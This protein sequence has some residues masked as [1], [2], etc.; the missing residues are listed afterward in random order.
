MKCPYCIPNS[1]STSK[2]HRGAIKRH[3]IMNTAP[4]GSQISLFVK[5]RGPRDP[6]IVTISCDAFVAELKK[7]IMDE[8]HV[9]SAPDDVTLQLEEPAQPPRRLHG[10][11]TLREERVEDRAQITLNVPNTVLTS[12]R[13]LAFN[14][15]PSDSD[16]RRARV[17][18]YSRQMLVPAFGAPTQDTLASLSVLIVGGGGLG[19][20]VAMYLAGAG[21]GRITVVDGDTV[22]VSNLHRQVAH[23]EA[24]CGTRKA[25]SLC[26]AMRALNSRGCFD[27]IGEHLTVSNAAA[28]VAAADIVVDCTD[29]SGSRYLINDACVF[30]GVPLV[31]GAALGTDGQLS[32]Y[33]H[34]GG[35]CYRCIFPVPPPR[36]VR[37]GGSCSNAGVLGPVTGVIGSLQAME[38]LKIASLMA[39]QKAHVHVAAHGGATNQPLRGNQPLHGGVGVLGNAQPFLSPFEGFAGGVLSGR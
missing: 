26:A 6:G 30:A 16:S 23:T 39:A 12:R 38:V 11:R 10:A 15:A 37:E 36:I 29:N 24:R 4:A 17:L 8:F 3:V 1:Y 14:A 32:V 9:Q 22:D 21:V 5:R 34:G 13:H 35:P 19:C 33:N 28:I 31:S 27:A 7:R 2:L 18:R 20:P 25:D